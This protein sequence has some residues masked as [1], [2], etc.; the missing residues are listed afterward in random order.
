MTKEFSFKPH[1][2]YDLLLKQANAMSLLIRSLQKCSALKDLDLQRLNREMAAQGF[3][4]INAQRETNEILTNELE[5]SQKRIQEQESDLGETIAERDY[6]ESKATELA[7]DVGKALGIHIGEHTSRN[8]PVQNAIEGLYKMST[9]IEIWRAN[10]KR[11]QELEAAIRRHKLMH[12][13]PAE[14]TTFEDSFISSVDFK[15]WEVLND[16]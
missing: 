11:I 10:E 9:Q 7:E 16:E 15:L 14:L 3:E 1:K 6:W 12:R 2:E 8:C 4:E 5:L 13:K